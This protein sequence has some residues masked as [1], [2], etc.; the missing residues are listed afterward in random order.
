MFSLIVGDCFYIFPMHT[1]SQFSSEKKIIVI[2]RVDIYLLNNPRIFKL[3]LKYFC[4][5][6]SII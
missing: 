2:F 4:A 3:F 5:K 6:F 1:K